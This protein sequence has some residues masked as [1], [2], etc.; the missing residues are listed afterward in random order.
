MKSGHPSQ[1]TPKKVQ[2]AHEKWEEIP[3][4]KMVFLAQMHQALVMV[5][6]NISQGLEEKLN[7]NH[8]LIESYHFTTTPFHSAL[9]TCAVEA[10]FI[11]SITK[12]CG[13]VNQASGFS[14]FS[15]II[16]CILLFSTPN[17]VTTNPLS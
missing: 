6:I 9:C 8:A 7:F 13:Q 3:E 1:T 4:I 17:Q 14:L 5:I 10:L 16:L 12:S 15:P 11:H 2:G